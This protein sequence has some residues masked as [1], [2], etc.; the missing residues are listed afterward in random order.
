MIAKARGK[1]RLRAFSKLT[2]RVDGELR[3]AS[4]PPVL[5]PLEELYSGKQLKTAE[6]RLGEV[7]GG[8]RET[9]E[10]R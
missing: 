9:L 3:I 8:Y 5:V 7:I 10:C 6:S 2:H 1:D 4:D